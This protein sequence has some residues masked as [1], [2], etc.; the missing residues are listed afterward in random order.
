MPTFVYLMCAAEARV[1]KTLLSRL[2]LDY[3]ASTFDSALGFDTNI[4]DPVLASTFPDLTKIVDFGSSRGPVTLFDSLIRPDGVPK[5]V[6]LWYISHEAF[7]S[8]ARQLGFFEEAKRNS[9]AVVILLFP[10]LR[11]GHIDEITEYYALVSVQNNWLR[12]QASQSRYAIVLP[13][14]DRELV[15]MLARPNVLTYQVLHSES[16]LSSTY[17]FDRRNSLAQFFL[18]VEDL[19][20]RIAL[21]HSCSSEHRLK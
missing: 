13:T 9:I 20:A 15:Q 21:E 8:Q 10:D 19:E 16:A 14:L 12:R 7:F 18:Q 6:D 3:L 5:V 17:P 11:V 4:R 1:G 2:Y